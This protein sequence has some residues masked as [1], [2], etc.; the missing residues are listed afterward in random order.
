[1]NITFLNAAFND[2]LIVRGHEKV[3]FL[4]IQLSVIEQ[5][6]FTAHHHIL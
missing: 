2:S 6:L 4:S 1:M 3:C 5:E